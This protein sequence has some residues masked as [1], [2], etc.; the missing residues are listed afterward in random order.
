MEYRSVGCLAD[1]RAVYDGGVL[2]DSSCASKVPRCKLLVEGGQSGPNVIWAYEYQARAPGRAWVPEAF[3]CPTAQTA[4]AVPDAATIRDRV[5]K[6]LPAVAIRSTGS[7]ATLVNVQTILWADTAR[8]RALGRVSVVGQPV[9]LR[10]VFDRAN[11]D[12]GDGTTDSSGSPGKVYDP[13]GDRCAQV[14]CADYYGHVYRTAGPV[15]IRLTVSWRASYS[16]DGAHFSPVD[17]AALTGPVSTHAL[18]VRQ[19]R[20]VLVPDPNGN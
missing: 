3:W 13:D 2:T 8:A 10:L 12:F 4:T 14:L 19:A 15:T 11:W 18:R 6:L 16:L 20:T 7:A 5:L 9:W 1:G 17:A